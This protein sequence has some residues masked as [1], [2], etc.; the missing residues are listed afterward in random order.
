MIDEG[1]LRCNVCK[2]RVLVTKTC[3]VY[4]P[5]TKA[6]EEWDVCYHCCKAKR[7]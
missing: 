6:I 3:K 4:V 7:W 2:M 5:K 1:H